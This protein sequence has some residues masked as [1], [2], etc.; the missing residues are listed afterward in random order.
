MKRWYSNRL[1]FIDTN[2][3]AK[4]VLSLPEGPVAGGTILSLTALPGSTI[5]YTLDGTDPRARGGNPTPGALTYSGPIP[6]NANIRVVARA[7]DLNH[8]NLTGANK[9]PLTSPWSGPAAATFVVQTPPLRITEIMYHPAPPPVGNTNDADNFEYLEVMNT[10][11]ASL[12]LAGFQLSGGIDVTLTNLSLAASQR[13]VVVRDVV[14]FRSRYGDSALI[15]GVY[16]N[17]LAN[18]GDHVVLRGPVLEPILDF[19]YDDDWYP[20]TDGLGFSL[21]VVDENAP[22]TNWVLQTQWR[23]NGQLAG[24]PGD[25]DLALPAFPVVRVNEVLAHTDLPLV[26]TVELWN[27]GPAAADVSGW[28]LSDKFDQPARFRIL[29]NAVIPAGQYVCFDSANLHPTT[30]NGFL[31]SELGD[32]LYLFSA[33][34]N[35]NLTGYVHGFDFGASEN[36]VSFGRYV[37]SVGEEHFVAQTAFTLGT[38]N[39]G[40]RV[41]PVVIN[42]IMFWPPSVYSTNNNNRDEFI[43]LHNV[44]GTPVPLYDPQTTNQLGLSTNT[45]KVTGG[46]E[47]EL[48]ASVTLPAQGFLLL[49]GFDPVLQPGEL[50]AFRSRYGLDASTTILGPYRG[51]LE[52]TGEHVKLLKPGQPE[53]PESLRPGFVPDIL[54]DAVHYLNLS[55]WPTN[56][57]ASSNSLQRI[58]ATRYGNDPINW[59]AASPTPGAI[60]QGSTNPDRDGDGLPNEWETTYGLNPDSAVGADG[61]AGDPDGDGLTNQQEYVSGTD[62]RDPNSYLKVDSITNDPNGIEVRFRAVAGKTYTVLY[63]SQVETGIWQKLTDVPAQPATGEIGVPDESPQAAG[64]RFYRLVMPQP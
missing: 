25:A 11:T 48:P 2:F 12:N 32:A 33:D 40:P 59:Q 53:P 23:P 21:A 13:A 64:S 39:A 35:T 28:L 15:A 62:P 43:E 3:L 49:V 29:T 45:W 42:E 9:P 5:F 31:L 47:F 63:R 16:T 34:A 26:D 8:Q 4:P 38:N 56:A 22:L 55:P 51:Q 52:N 27:A 50:A 36:G 19:T 58:A 30:T 46:V 41:G 37:T 54:V 44:T 60:N 24:T 7:R 10:G 17:N 6:I 18:D 61:A 1:D 20:I 14:A 57:S